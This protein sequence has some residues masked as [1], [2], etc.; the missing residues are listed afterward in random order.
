MLRN[1]FNEE[2]E[3]IGT[4]PIVAVG[5]AAM[6]KEAEFKD[7]TGK[8][9]IYFQRGEIDLPTPPYI[10]EAAYAAMKEGK[11]RYSK[12]GGEPAVRAALAAYQAKA[13]GLTELTG[14]NIVLTYGGIQALLLCFKLFKG[15][16][17]AGFSPCWS[18]VLKNL[19]PFA[20]VNFIEIPLH[21]DFSIDYKALESVLDEVEFFY[22]NTPHNPTGK[23]FHEDEV[24]RI[25]D[26]CCQKDVFLISDEA[27]ERVIYDGKKYTSPLSFGKPNII[28]AFTFSKTFAMTGWRLG[29]VATTNTKLNRLL[30]IGNY[31][32]TAGVTTFVQYA[33]KIALEQT[34][35]REQAIADMMAEFQKRRNALYDGITEIDGIKIDRPEGAFYMFPNFT[36][37]IPK[38]LSGEKREL[39]ISGKLMEHGVVTVPGAYFGKDFTD[40]VRISFSLTPVPVVEEAVE[41]FRAA[42]T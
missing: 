35:K 15:A 24:T 7:L 1:I 32:Q 2:F 4:S 9:F 12:S 40:N 22:P 6:E 26:L 5:E 13:T 25:V 41:R 11:T 33:G 28:S 31:T 19:V 20:G 23:V 17:G 38:E 3:G 37:L 14:D 10:V 36:D 8:G 34:E 16:T 39:Y 27:Y 30:K 42:F 29:Y 18:C 21:E